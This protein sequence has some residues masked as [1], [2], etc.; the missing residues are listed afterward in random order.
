VRRLGIILLREPEIV[1]GLRSNVSKL[2]GKVNRMSAYERRVTDKLRRLKQ[3]R[4][5]DDEYVDRLRGAVSFWV[6][7]AERFEKEIP[8]PLPRASQIA[9][10]YCDCYAFGLELAGKFDHAGQRKKSGA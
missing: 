8:D 9:G 5:L 1:T 7:R 6:E 10:L 2:Q 3:Q 4:K